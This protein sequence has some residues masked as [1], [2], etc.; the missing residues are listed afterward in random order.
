[1]SSPRTISAPGEGAVLRPRARQPRR[2]LGRAP[3]SVA[4][5][6][7]DA[8]LALFTITTDLARLQFA[9]PDVGEPV[10]VTSVQLGG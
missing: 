2:Y 3:L 8:D 1:M 7:K 6:C 5:R 10:G 4:D 9:L